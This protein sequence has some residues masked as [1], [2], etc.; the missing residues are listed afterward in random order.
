MR[1][2]GGPPKPSP[3][4]G[5]H[6]K[7]RRWTGV[8][9]CSE[10]PRQP[11]HRRP[12]TSPWWGKPPVSA[13]F[14]WIRRRRRRRGDTGD[15]RIVVRM[16]RGEAEGAGQLPSVLRHGRPVDRVK[17]V[18]RAGHQ[19]STKGAGAGRDGTVTDIPVLRPDSHRGAGLPQRCTEGDRHGVRG[20]LHHLAGRTDPDHP[21]IGGIGESRS[22]GAD[23]DAPSPAPATDN[24]VAARRTPP[25]PFTLSH[26]ILTE[27]HS[28]RRAGPPNRRRLTHRTADIP[29]IT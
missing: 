6:R 21:G 18:G 11:S 14:R 20:E 1:S 25:I 13:E 23:Q 15:Q 8:R 2:P 22:R 7:S 16:A 9:H 4:E 28:R 27:C 24:A 29:V 19:I 10:Q 3:R 5:T 12:P 26:N 17:P